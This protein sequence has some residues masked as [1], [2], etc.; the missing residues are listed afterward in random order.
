MGDVGV[1]TGN[2][3][4]SLYWN[5]AKYGAT[6]QLQSANPGEDFRV[7]VTFDPWLRQLVKDVWL[8]SIYGS[9]IIDDKSALSASFRFFSLG[10][11]TFTNIQGEVIGNYIPVEYALDFAY[12][13]K[14]SEHW[15]GAVAFRYILSNLT[16]G[17]E[18]A[19]TTTKPGKAVAADLAAYYET[20]L[21]GTDNTFTFGVNISNIGNKISYSD[22]NN[23]RDFIPTLLRLGPGI[24][25]HANENHMFRFSADFTKLLVP[26]PP[27]YATDPETGEVI[28]DNQDNP[29]IAKGMSSDVS[30]M[31]GMFQSFYDAPR[32]F[33]EEMH[34]ITT[35]IGAVIPFLQY[36]LPAY[37]LVR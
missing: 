26:T 34:E 14:L 25:W 35:A 24:T 17:Q 13:R 33:N 20:K 23:H 16:N 5:P 36:R 29:V 30:V 12:S 32:G 9:K 11:I 8:G 21:S 31:R 28:Y 18:V 6:N 27:I 1:A 10:D 22:D 4:F 19:G 7:A 2:D 15:S 3:V 37:R